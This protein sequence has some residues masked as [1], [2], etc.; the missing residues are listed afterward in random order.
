MNKINYKEIHNNP[1]VKV[2]IA[3]PGRV[4]VSLYNKCQHLFHIPKVK[5]VKEPYVTEQETLHRGGREL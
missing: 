5:L 3:P 2:E 4:L 1:S